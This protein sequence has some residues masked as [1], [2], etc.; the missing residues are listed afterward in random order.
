[1]RNHRLIEQIMKRIK[2]LTPI[3]KDLSQNL[4][5]ELVL[6]PEQEKKLKANLPSWLPEKENVG[7]AM[8]QTG[9]EFLVMLEDILETDFGFTEKDKIRLEKKV[10]Q[11]LPV[12][13]EMENRGLSILSTHDMAKIGEIAEIRLLR[14]EG[15]GKLPTKTSVKLLEGKK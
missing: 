15:K 7:T 4:V 14:L 1:M 11:V 12:L 5:K 10:K 13:H 6:T 2:A 9:M 8:L 3:T